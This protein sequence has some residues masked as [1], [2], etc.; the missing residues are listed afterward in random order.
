[1]LDLQ[2][3]SHQ[4]TFYFENEMYWSAAATLSMRSAALR[5]VVMG[6]W[7]GCWRQSRIIRRGFARAP[8]SGMGFFPI[9][10]IGGRGLR[11]DFHD[12]A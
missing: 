9:V 5:V 11:T 2:R 10:R 12:D 8:S 7:P 4:E 1:V 3:F 6:V